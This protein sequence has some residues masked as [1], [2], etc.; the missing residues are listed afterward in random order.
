MIVKYSKFKKLNELALSK[1]KLDKETF[2]NNIDLS[3]K[4][5][6]DFN[7]IVD[8]LKNKIRNCNDFDYKIIYD[9][10]DDDNQFK[11]N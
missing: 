5:L 4:S 7:N 10:N 11:L 1:G 6:K 8:K 9:E 3:S 2:F